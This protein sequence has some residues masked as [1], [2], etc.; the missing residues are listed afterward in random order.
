MKGLR[1]A[2][3]EESCF[4]AWI[5]SHMGCPALLCG[6]FAESQGSLFQA[7]K[8]SIIC[9]AVQKG[10]C[11][12]DIHDFFSSY[13]T[14]GYGL[15]RSVRADCHECHFRSRIV[16]IIAGPYCKRVDFVMFTKSGFR[17]P[18]L[19][20]WAVLSSN[21]VDLLMLRNRVFRHRNNQKCAVNS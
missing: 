4:E 11:S 14:F 12:A 7:S 3:T 10:G 9:S 19:E 1:F 13:K 20:I 18:K 15:C 6:R 17:V 8:R 2:V 16:Q 21:E 5:R